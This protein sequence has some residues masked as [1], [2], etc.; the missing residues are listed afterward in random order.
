MNHF[1]IECGTLR[2][3]KGIIT[4]LPYQVDDADVLLFDLQ[5]KITIAVTSKGTAD[6]VNVL[7]S[8]EMI[9]HTKYTLD[10]KLATSLATYLFHIV[11]SLE[12]EYTTS[13]RS[14]AAPLLRRLIKHDKHESD[15]LIKFDWKPI[16]KLINHY[17]FP[18]KDKQHLEIELD[19]IKELLA[20]LHCIT[21]TFGVGA[22]RAIWF[23]FP[24]EPIHAREQYA[25]SMSA[26]TYLLPCTDAEL[27]TRLLIPLIS[28]ASSSFWAYRTTEYDLCRLTILARI[29]RKHPRVISHDLILMCMDT[30]KDKL[31]LPRLDTTSVCPGSG[32]FGL[33]GSAQHE[34]SCKILTEYQRGKHYGAKFCAYM[35]NGDDCD[36]V[37]VLHSFLEP[38]NSL[39]HP[40]NV[41]KWSSEI[42]EF[43]RS[44]CGY[45]SKRCAKSADYTPPK[46]FVPLCWKLLQNLMLS[47]Q[48]VTR[49][50]ASTALQY[51]SSFSTL[52]VPEI[53]QSLNE[54]F[55]TMT[56]PLR[57]TALIGALSSCTRS[58]ACPEYTPQVLD[59]LELLVT[60]INPTDYLRTF[61][62]LVFYANTSFFVALCNLEDSPRLL[63]I[64]LL[65]IDRILEAIRQLPP[66]EEEAT[67]NLET[68]LSHLLSLSTHSF[69]EHLSGDTLLVLLKRAIVFLSEETHYDARYAVREVIKSLRGRHA[70]LSMQVLL[71]F[72]VDSIPSLLEH[73]NRESS[74]TSIPRLLYLLD[75]LCY[76]VKE[77]AGSAIVPHADALL[78]LLLRVMDTDQKAAVEL[79]SKTVNNLL[80]SL[81]D[82][83]PSE[84]LPLNPDGTVPK[85]VAELHISWNAAGRDEIQAFETCIS[86][87]VES[88]VQA[89]SKGVKTNTL[90]VTKVMLNTLNHASSMVNPR[91]KLSA[92]E[93][94]LPFDHLY[95]RLSSL[96]LSHCQ[97]VREENVEM[98]NLYIDCLGLLLLKSVGFDSKHYELMCS[99]AKT[100]K[101]LLGRYPKDKQYPRA[102]MVQL[103]LNLQQTRHKFALY[104][105]N[106]SR[107]ADPVLEELFRFATGPYLKL[108]ETALDYL[109]DSHIKGQRISQL[110]LTKICDTLTTPNVS[111][112]T[113]KGC[114]NLLT[115][116]ITQLVIPNVSCLPR[117]CRTIEYLYLN[118]NTSTVHAIMPN[119][120]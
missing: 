58:L 116:G 36:M 98:Q 105:E 87:L 95:S 34:R 3:D 29:A 63:D 2:A 18:S 77:V 20:R 112:D 10:R 96:L 79:A 86:R 71:P 43:L 109:L 47:H 28:D 67:L 40:T 99:D 106:A 118:P 13:L 8:I 107:S 6:I 82:Y 1:E 52:F 22:D 70:T 55:G 56:S 61:E 72:F 76:L 44:L 110:T 51:L 54:S 26:L 49:R 85:R 50:A 17:L 59:F 103:T 62:V 83:T 35:L 25:K 27:V 57:T 68:G 69:F 46:G 53:L 64:S 65:F 94:A 12:E 117:L 111:K 16:A 30:L 90:Q 5:E 14:T 39:C 48:L 15:P 91:F 60:S 93:F 45:V 75:I 114:F 31:H 41:G 11:T 7:D 24:L 80:V 97:V 9:L 100:F 92:L 74:D 115:A 81:I 119:H 84:A 120:S 19:N 104:L 66:V 88:N 102:L 23:T 37:S 32:S 108:Q 89:L 78:S 4:K 21:V 113:F 38:L 101:A 42:A 73:V 33:A